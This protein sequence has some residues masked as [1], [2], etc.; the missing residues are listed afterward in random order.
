MECSVI[1]HARS[2]VEEQALY[3]GCTNGMECRRATAI[4]IGNGDLM[5]LAEEIRAIG[6]GQ[7]LACRV[8]ESFCFAGGLLIAF[9]S[10][11]MSVKSPQADKALCS[12]AESKDGCRVRITAVK[13]PS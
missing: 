12:R 13:R 11:G 8:F 7:R 6:R 10:K 9:R 2:T 1:L 3:W 4:S 5:L